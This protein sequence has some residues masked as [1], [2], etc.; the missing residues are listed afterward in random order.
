MEHTKIRLQPVFLVSLAYASLGDFSSRAATT[1]FAQATA[2]HEIKQLCKWIAC[3][4][5]MK[6]YIL[7]KKFIF[8]ETE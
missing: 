5:H 3:I 7:V 6:A 4:S 2:V 8:V 1:C